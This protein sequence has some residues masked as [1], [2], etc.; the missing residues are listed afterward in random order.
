M[1]WVN[2]HESTG[3]C[4][5]DY[6]ISN[7]SIADFLSA[8]PAGVNVG[9]TWDRNLAYLRGL[10]MGAE[11][12]GKGADVLLRPAVGPL[13]RFPDGG[14][15]WEGFS[16]DPY[17]SGEMVG[18]TIRGIQENGIMA[19]VKHYIAN[20]QEHFRQTTEAQ[21]IL[22][23]SISEPI[24]SNLDD[25]TMHEIYLWYDPCNLFLLKQTTLLQ[26]NH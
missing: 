21:Q 8:F 18:P 26:T 4:F 20:E 22:N 3:R 25:K 23:V 1:G 10:A 9:A 13:G 2:Q 6:F 5:F 12:K 14:R 11:W 19:T 7:D 15:N 24:S 17:L 16:P